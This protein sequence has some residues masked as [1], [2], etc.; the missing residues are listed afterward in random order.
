M[1]GA[2]QPLLGFCRK[3]ETSWACPPSLFKLPGPRTVLGPS[4]ICALLQRGL[5]LTG[6]PQDTCSLNPPKRDVRPEDSDALPAA[7]EQRT[8]LRWVGLSHVL[9]GPLA[10]ATVPASAPPLKRR[11]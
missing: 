9:S 7:S 8:A 5:S 3:P 2:F 6:P 1:H 4:P 11:M 10:Q